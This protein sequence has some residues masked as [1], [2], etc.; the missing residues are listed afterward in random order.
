[1]WGRCRDAAA[2]ADDAAAV[3]ADDRDGQV[4]SVLARPYASLSYRELQKAAK[5]RGLRAVGKA[6]EIR[7]RLEAAENATA[8]GALAS[9]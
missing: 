1:M 7:A 6:E 2:D 9:S 3:R 8:D 4:A 5:A